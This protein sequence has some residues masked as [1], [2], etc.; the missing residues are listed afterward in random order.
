MVVRIEQSCRASEE[1][2]RQQGYVHCYVQS[3]K[4]RLQGFCSSKQNE[5]WEAQEEVKCRQQGEAQADDI[6][7]LPKRAR[8]G[9]TYFLEVPVFWQNAEGGVFFC[10]GIHPIGFTCSTVHINLFRRTRVVEGK[11]GQDW[12]GGKGIV[13][14]LVYYM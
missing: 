13:T 9:K 11:A 6:D 5:R 4:C 8:Q 12:G 1:G 10:C 14:L 3:L 7:F 2:R